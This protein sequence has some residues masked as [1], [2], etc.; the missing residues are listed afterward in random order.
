MASPELHVPID[1]GE[2]GV[3][4][5]RGSLMVIGGDLAYPNPSDY[6]YENRLFRPFEDALP[7]PRHYHPGRVVDDLPPEHPAFGLCDCDHGFGEGLDEGGTPSTPSRAV[8]GAS[9]SCR[10]LRKYEGPQCFAIPGNHDWIDGLET[11]MR[12]FVCKGW[13]G[14]WMLPQEK[15][16]FALRLPR[17]WWLFGL[18]LGLVNDI[19]IFQYRYFAHLA[20][21]R[22]GPT[23]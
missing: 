21:S 15:S 7:P 6:T 8:G 4:L 18:D 19:D 1:G 22:L 16:Y 11:F 9:W 5:Q 10:A 23:T 13:L 3:T 14:G 17:G 2:G 20:S 12:H